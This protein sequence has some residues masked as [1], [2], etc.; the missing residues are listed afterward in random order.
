MNYILF[1][2]DEDWWLKQKNE[3]LPNSVIEGKDILLCP[4]F[5]IYICIFNVYFV[6]LQKYFWE[7]KYI[8]WVDLILLPTTQGDS[9]WIML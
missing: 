4:P 1:S 8:L 3:N 9:E 6:H 7:E 5:P 2:K